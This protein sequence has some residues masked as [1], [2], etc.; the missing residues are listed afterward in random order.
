[1]YLTSPQHVFNGLPDLLL[2]DADQPH[3]HRDRVP[4]H[5]ALCRVVSEH[6][7]RAQAHIRH[8]FERSRDDE[9]ESP[10][11]IALEQPKGAAHHDREPGLRERPR[12]G[13]YAVGISGGIID[14][15]KQ[16]FIPLTEMGSPPAEEAKWRHPDAERGLGGYMA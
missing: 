2:G 16:S 12:K 14:S 7:Q 1:M 8:W 10:H 5:E 15:T 3:L 9:F 6:A 4:P 11:D 13:V